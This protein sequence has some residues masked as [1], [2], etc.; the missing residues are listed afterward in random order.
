MK[1]IISIILVLTITMS[2]YAG[3]PNWYLP[4]IKK[5]SYKGGDALSFENAVI[6]KKAETMEI[7]I[8]AEYIYIQKKQGKMFKKW[9]PLDN[10]L[11]KI[12]DRSYSTITIQRISN[13]DITLK[14]IFDVTDFYGKYY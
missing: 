4:G 13:P 5:V 12:N 7:G 14:Y 9:R 10:T 6:V 2:C 8:M 3:K 11:E 1:K